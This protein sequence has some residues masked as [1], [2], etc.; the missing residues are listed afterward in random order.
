MVENDSPTKAGR[1]ARAAL[2]F[3]SIHSS[4]IGCRRP[5]PPQTRHRTRTWPR[6]PAPWLAHLGGFQRGLAALGQRGRVD[7]LDHL[8]RGG[9][10]SRAG[11][12]C[13]GAGPAAIRRWPVARAAHRPPWVG[14]QRNAIGSK[15]RSQGVVHLAG[16]HEEL[17]APGPSSRWA[18]KT[19]CVTSLPRRFSSQAMSSTLE[20]SDGWRPAPASQRA[21]RPTCRGGLT[22]A[23]QVLI[24]ARRAGQGSP[25]TPRPAGRGRCAVARPGL[26]RGAQLRPWARP[27]TWP[28]THRL[29]PLCSCCA[30]HS[31]VVR[32]RARGH[33]EEAD[34]TARQ[35][36]LGLLPV[37][38]VG[39]QHGLRA[40]HRQRRHRARE[41]R[42]PPGLASAPAGIPTNAGPPTA[43]GAC[44]PC[45]TSASRTSERRDLI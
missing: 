1:R 18:R 29:W 14:R 10:A 11:P 13:S 40:R 28:S 35:L 22:A 27:S 38:A 6:R 32:R 5:A 4:S 24:D 31:D 41:P 37:A 30:S 23:G 19:G 12:G 15:A 7:L 20:M 2:S 45:R 42:Q 34:A 43:P 44:A 16:A 9:T 3:V 33:L 21:R 39:K 36:A 8:G 17:A 26:Q 25:P